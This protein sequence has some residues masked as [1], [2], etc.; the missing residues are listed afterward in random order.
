MSRPLES[1]SNRELMHII[2]VRFRALHHELNSCNSHMDAE[3]GEL[4]SD[5]E[6]ASDLKH[7]HDRFWEAM[8]EAYARGNVVMPDKQRIPFGEYLKR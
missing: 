7:Y 6:Y 5:D 3:E 4:L 1:L 2:K 8:D